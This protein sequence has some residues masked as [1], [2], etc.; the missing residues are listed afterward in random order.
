MTGTLQLSFVHPGRQRVE[1]LAG[2]LAAF[3]A[4]AT[5]T[6]EVAIYDFHFGDGDGGGVIA[7]SLV[8]AEA[9]GVRVLLVDHDERAV[10][11]HTVV[12]PPPAE[13]P[14]Y[15][16]SLGL[17]VTPVTDRFGLMHHKYVVAD[18][19]RVWTGSMNWTPDAFTLQENCFVRA[20]SADLARAYRRNFEEL[21]SLGRI[22]GTGDYDAPA[23]EL[24]LDG[25]RV[26]ARP[27]FCPG[28]GPELASAIA[29]A[30]RCARRRVLVCSPVLTS[31]PILG[32]LTDVLDRPGLTV[33]GVVDRTM[34][35]GVLHQWAVEGKGSW[36]PDAFRFVSARAGFSGRASTPWSPSNPHDYMHAKITIVDDTA[37]VGSYN[38]SRSGEENAENVLTLEGAAAADRLAAFV[39]EVIERYRET[40]YARP[41]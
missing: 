7:R 39:G 9:R 8:E 27:L 19:T 35:D 32:A 2:E 41:S 16:D 25:E 6:V 14:E 5:R 17:D 20:E 23:V 38:H 4:S 26:L 30:I 31:G 15:V 10:P 1:D 22:E 13:P 11:E 3:V 28:R 40:G 29:A 33:H 21:R 18:G 24:A 37:F 36:K 34:M 12:C